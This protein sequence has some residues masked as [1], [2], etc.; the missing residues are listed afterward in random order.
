MGLTSSAAANRSGENVGS[1]HERGS[2]EPQKPQTC[3]R[4]LSLTEIQGCLPDFTLSG[5]Q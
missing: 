2:Q 1:A 3:W 5:R 4:V